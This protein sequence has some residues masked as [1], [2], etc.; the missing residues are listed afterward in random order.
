MTMCTYIEAMSMHSSCM[1]T[2]HQTT[3]PFSELSKIHSKNNIPKP[4]G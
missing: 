3:E 2:T 1:H 4:T